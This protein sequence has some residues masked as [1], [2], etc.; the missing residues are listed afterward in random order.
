MATTPG[1]P[2]PPA[3]QTITTTSDQLYKETTRLIAQALQGFGFGHQLVHCS[4]CLDF[5]A[6]EGSTLGDV[7][8]KALAHECGPVTRPLALVVDDSPA[9]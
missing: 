8:A 4:A 7:V 3:V 1:A 6:I 9:G 5:W 2:V